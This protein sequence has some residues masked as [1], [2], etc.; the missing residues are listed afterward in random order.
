MIL[1]EKIAHGDVIVLD[2]ATGTEIER[3]GAKMDSAAWCAIANMNHPE[4]VRQVHESYM[5][6]GA[7]VIT[8][9]TFEPAVMFWLVPGWT[10][11]PSR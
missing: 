6:A 10:A 5:R 9:N 2:G 7:D 1:D 4:K 8:T 11:I 3:L